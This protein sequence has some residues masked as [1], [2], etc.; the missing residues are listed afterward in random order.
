MKQFLID[1]LLIYLTSFALFMMQAFLL[2]ESKRNNQTIPYTP[3][4]LFFLKKAY[5]PVKYKISLEYCATFLQ[6]ITKIICLLVFMITLVEYRPSMLCF[7]KQNSLFAL[8]V[9]STFDVKLRQVRRMIKIGFAKSQIPIFN[10]FSLQYLRNK[11]SFIEYYE[12]I[13]L[14]RA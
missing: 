5:V 14:V 1:K 2:I 11:E 9:L 4:W 10:F 13:I 12:V 3:S 7:I 6:K 8:I